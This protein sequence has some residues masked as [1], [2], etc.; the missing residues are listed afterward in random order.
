MRLDRRLRAR[1]KLPPF[2]VASLG[3]HGVALATLITVPRAWALVVGA[4][5]ANQVG[6]GVAGLLP[7][8]GWLGPTI[9]RLPQGRAC[10]RLV[11][12]TF[13]DGPDPDVTPAVLR[14]LEQSSAK[15]TFFC[16][17]RRAEAHPGLVAA[18][19]AQGHGVENHSYSHPN[20]FALRGPSRIASQI[21]RAQEAI[22]LSGGGRPS[23]FRAP[24]GF[25]NPWLAS[26][27]AGA[28]LRLV[29][30]TRRGF[31]T[32]SHDDARVA[33]RLLRRIQGGDILVL[34]DGSAARG[35]AGRPVVL[36]ALPRVLDR[37]SAEGLRSEPLHRLL[38]AAPP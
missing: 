4:V 30:W 15:A 18:I 11:A 21:R 36:D 17:G 19:R 8:C 2:L 35:V 9:T 24:L 22:E 3:L 27:V 14:L 6:I 7:R 26:A 28:G 13:D 12:L 23:F 16:I 34:H 32:V 33:A 25:Q 38:G 1:P 29:S 37:M 10:E 5:V 20:A 31:D